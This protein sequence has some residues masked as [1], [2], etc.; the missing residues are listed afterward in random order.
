MYPV[1]NGLE[2]GPPG[3]VVGDD[4]RMRAAVVALG[5]G[6]EALLACSVPHLHLEK[7]GNGGGIRSSHNQGELAHLSRLQNTVSWVSL[8]DI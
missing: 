7:D 5:D 6:P 4:G 1:R 8:L 3:E 2:G